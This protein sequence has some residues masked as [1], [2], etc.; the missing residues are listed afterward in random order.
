MG[1][2]A[3]KVYLVNP[4]LQLVEGSSIQPN[5]PSAMLVGDSIANPPGMTTPFVTV[6]QNI[7]ATYSFSDQSGKLQQQSRRFCSNRR[8]AT[9]WKQSDRQ[10]SYN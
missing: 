6:G 2:D 10:S 4:S 8:D 7:K 5:N 3:S 9:F 1:M